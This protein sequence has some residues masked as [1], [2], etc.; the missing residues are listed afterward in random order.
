METATAEQT[1]NGTTFST[2]NDREVVIVRT[3]DVPL[4]L[5]FDAWTK[6]EHLRNW[7]VGHGDW[8]MTACEIDLRPGGAWRFAWR[9]TNGC[10]MAIG[11]TYRE[12]TPPARVVS[13]ESW[14]GDYPETLN[15]LAF[16]EVGGLTRVSKTILYPTKAARDAA[17]ATS[18]RQGMAANL[19]RLA[20]YL[21]ELF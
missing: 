7:M 11:G 9:N 15:T 19:E 3:F 20:A 14:G 5:A 13:T 18:I 1:I 10:D 21:D 4:Q 6:P 17:S 8:T 16:D 2:P 12:V